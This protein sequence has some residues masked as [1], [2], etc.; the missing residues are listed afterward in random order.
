MA[1]SAASP[2][3]PF[4]ATYSA[5]RFS[6]N[7]SPPLTTKR[8]PITSAAPAPVNSAAISGTASPIVPATYPG[9]S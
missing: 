8:L 9:T 4:L 2:V 6:A 3:N 1:S 7:F 5:A